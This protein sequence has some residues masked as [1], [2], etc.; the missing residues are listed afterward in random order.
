MCRLKLNR[1][2]PRHW[3]L[4]A[5]TLKVPLSAQTAAGEQRFFVPTDGHRLITEGL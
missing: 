1:L 4:V 3:S 5:R 2:K